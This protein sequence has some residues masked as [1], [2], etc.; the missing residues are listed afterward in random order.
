MSIVSDMNTRSVSIVRVSNADKPAEVGNERIK[1]PIVENVDDD[2]PMPLNRPVTV[3]RVSKIP[4]L[5]TADENQEIDPEISSQYLPRLRS[6][7]SPKISRVSVIKLPRDKTPGT[8]RTHCIDANLH[9]Q[10]RMRQSA[11]ICSIPESDPVG[12]ADIGDWQPEN[13]ELDSTVFQRP[14]NSSISNVSVFK[15]KKSA[16]SAKPM[17]VT[18]KITP[19]QTDG[20]INKGNGVT[21]IKIPKKRPSSS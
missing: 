2:T 4:K 13:I 21:V 9:E 14:R 17:T 12:I 19:L 20:E 15:V 6:I 16:I 10:E 8:Q 3:H 18:R 11:A 7:S 1:P 5:E